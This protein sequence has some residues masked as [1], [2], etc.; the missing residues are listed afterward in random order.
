MVFSFPYSK[1]SGA[2]HHGIEPVLHAGVGISH[3]LS[4]PAP[5]QGS[6]EGSQEEGHLPQQEFLG[7]VIGP[8][9]TAQPE[10]EDLCAPMMADWMQGRRAGRS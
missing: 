3:A 9:P 2:L 6:P 5:A 8:R 7:P 1:G 4:P 10:E